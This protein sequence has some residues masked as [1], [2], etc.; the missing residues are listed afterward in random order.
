M[1]LFHKNDALEVFVVIGQ[2]GVDQN[3]DFRGTPTGVQE[4]P[5]GIGEVFIILSQ[6]LR[7]LVKFSNQIGFVVIIVDAERKWS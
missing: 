2:Q 6:H 3:H 1:P 7:Y 4:L 5:R